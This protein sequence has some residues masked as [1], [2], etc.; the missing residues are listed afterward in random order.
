M[1]NNDAVFELL[2]ACVRYQPFRVRSLNDGS[3]EALVEALG[4]WK[5]RTIPGHRTVLGRALTAMENHEHVR[6][7]NTRV[8][9]A[10]LTHADGSIPA[11]FQVQQL[12]G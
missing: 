5:T 2:I 9:L 10:V 12:E 11:V 1:S 7:D 4:K 8:K 6:Q 3:V